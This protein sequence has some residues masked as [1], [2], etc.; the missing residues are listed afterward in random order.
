MRR[1][2]ARV[3]IV[4]LAAGV[5]AIPCRAAAS[6]LDLYGFGPRATAM[7]TATV[8]DPGDP[9][10]VFYNPAGL[11]GP[12]TVQLSL[13][14]LWSAP[15]IT[16][17]RKVAT[18]DPDLATSEPEA[19]AGLLLGVQAPAGELAGGRLAVGFGLFL[20]STKV[21]RAEAVEPTRPQFLRY[22]NIPD[23]FSAQIAAAWRSADGVVAVGAGMQTLVDI[24]GDIGFGMDLVGGRLERRDVQ[25]EVAPELSPLAGVLIRPSP[26]LRLGLAWRA[27][28]ALE[29]DLPLRLELGPALQF[30]LRL[31]GTALYTPHQITGG[32]AW[33]LP[34]PPG[35]GL[36]LSAEATWAM[37]SRAPDPAPRISVDLGGELLDGLGLGEGLDVQGRPDHAGLLMSDTVIPRIGAEWRPVRDWA[38]RAGASWRPTPVPA[39]DGPANYADSDAFIAS[40]G[41]GWR[42]SDRTTV[43]GVAQWIEHSDRPV[44]K[45][46][47]ADA[48]GDYTI[49]GRVLTFQTGLRHAW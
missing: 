30:D 33:D 24:T 40:A 32:I 11:V 46:D 19:F 27:A 43:E 29:Y 44:T 48:V 38:V 4:A 9:S 34:E 36:T 12:D 17:K 49:V 31:Q 10:T 28:V 35:H 21:L 16:L 5:I 1:I 42:G 26:G 22:Q 18:D 47:R 7:G 39:P 2:L 8:A 25:V 37:W 20:P 41:L 6:A 3:G 13:G 15:D 45:T 23:A 14:G